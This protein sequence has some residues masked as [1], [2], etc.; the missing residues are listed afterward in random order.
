MWDKLWEKSW[1]DIK[2]MH[3]SCW[4]F[5]KIE[6][7]GFSWLAFVYGRLPGL[8]CYAREYQGSF[9]EGKLCL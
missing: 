1:C 8:V 9:G 7:Y 4:I 2:G 6:F 5:G 3:W